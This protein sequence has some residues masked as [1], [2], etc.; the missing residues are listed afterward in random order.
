MINLTLNIRGFK[1]KT[2]RAD[3]RMRQCMEAFELADAWDKAAGNYDDA[4]MHEALG[5]IV[6]CFGGQFKVDDL[7]DGYEG[8]PYA[9]IPTFLRSVIGYVADEMT[10]FPPRAATATGKAKAG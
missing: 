6:E 4:L 5:F 8:R 1:P 9:L 2:Y 7:M 10:D 3:I